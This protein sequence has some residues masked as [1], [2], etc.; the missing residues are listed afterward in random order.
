M[1]PRRTP[2]QERVLTTLKSL[3]RFISAQDLYLKL[4][5]T[6]QGMGL[7][8]VYRALDTLKREGQVQMRT[9]LTGESIYSSLQQ[10]E[11][12]MTCLECGQSFPLEDCPVHHLED[13]LQQSHKFKIYYHTLEFFGVC[14]QCTD[15]EVLA[16]SSCQEVRG[17][18]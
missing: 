3:K 12:H 13:A 17:G 4:R 7:A 2:N 11:H 14:E 6:D 1:K 10:D 5:A 15:S 16:D 9:L 8:T 18:S